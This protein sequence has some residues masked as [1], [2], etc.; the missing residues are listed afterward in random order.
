MAGLVCKIELSK[1]GGISIVVDNGNADMVQE[2]YIDGEKITIRV[3]DSENESVIEQTAESITMTC[4]DF[5]V[6]AET[7]T[8]TST[9]DSSYVS[10]KK[11]AIKSTEDMTITSAAKLTETITGEIS[12]SCD[13]DI[14]VTSKSNISSTATATLSQSGADLSYKADDSASLNASEVSIDGSTS[15]KMTS[16]EIKVEA[17]SQIDLKGNIANL[18]GDSTTISGSSIALG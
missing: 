18:T 2:C 8:C 5:I 4:K 13:A 3:K 10:E 14:T 9:E 17:S 16:S 1:T 15:A 6:N 12:V 11:M 7:I